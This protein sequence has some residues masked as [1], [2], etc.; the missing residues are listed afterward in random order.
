MT[1]S[2]DTQAMKHPFA[3]LY[4]SPIASSRTDDIWFFDAQTGWLVNS[5]GYVCKTNDGGN[6]WHP[7]FYVCPS[8]KGKPYLRCMGWGSRM[9]GW[10]GAVT[11]IAD[12]GLKNPDNY[13]NTLLHQTRD[14]GETWQPVLN[15]PKAA[16]AGICGFYAVNEKVAYGSGTNDPSLPGP[17]VIKTIDGGATWQLIDMSA[18]ADNLI[19]IYFFDENKGFVVGGKNEAV[20]PIDNPA[21]P[22][23]R[24]IHYVQLK[25]VVLRTLDG[26][27]TWENMAANTTGFMCGEWGWKIQFLDS[28]NGFISLENFASAAILKT[29][30]GGQTWTRHN[31]QDSSGKI[32]N[33]DLEGIGFLNPKQGWVGGWGDNF[34][35]LFNSYTEDGGITWVRQDN[36]PGD[37]SSDPRVRINRYRFIGSPPTTAYCSGSQVYKWPALTPKKAAFAKT[38]AFA[39]V[40][41]HG[42]T[43]KQACANL[44]QAASAPAHDFALSC[45]KLADGTWEISYQ[46]PADSE[47]V[48]VGLWN[49]FAFYV[50]TVVHAE[51]QTQGRQSVIWDGNDGE[52]KPVGKGVFICRLSVD[53]RQGGSSN[54]TLD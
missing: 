11:G 38:A 43:R 30:D 18:H 1:I 32:I 8:S 27:Q 39:R 25:P 28:L 31:V 22:A 41:P 45:T 26:G 44:P 14:G 53:G 51:V 6:C 9:V 2:S 15:L 19:D 10:F 33:V 47:H 5:S 7:K 46:L 21:Y 50:A 48:F 49:K 23:P 54:I 12:D 3:T 35:G 20:C 29:T 4:N 34:D 13:L 37:S 52:G 36:I 24:L 40:E 17:G 16:P 42:A